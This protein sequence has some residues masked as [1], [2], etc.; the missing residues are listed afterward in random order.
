MDELRG[1]RLTS[2]FLDELQKI[3]EA[4]IKE[5]HDKSMIKEE[6]V[7]EVAEVKRVKDPKVTSPGQMFGVQ[8]S[9]MRDGSAKMK[10]MILPVPG[11][12]FNPELQKFVPNL[13]EPGWITTGEEMVARAKREGYIQGKKE[14][15]MSR[16]QEQATQFT[17]SIQQP[18]AEGQVPSPPQSQQA[19]QQQAQQPQQQAQQPAQQ[20]QMQN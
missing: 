9:K 8:F 3:A 15:A 7:D 19:Q 6:V 17:Q 14:E 5:N 11:H 4:E 1:M 10:P 12:T 18:A 13:D 2:I 16:L 20:Q